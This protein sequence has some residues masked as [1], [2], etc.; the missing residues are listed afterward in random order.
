[1][2]MHEKEKKEKN[3]SCKRRIRKTKWNYNVHKMFDKSKKQK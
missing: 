3:M 2:G 1:M